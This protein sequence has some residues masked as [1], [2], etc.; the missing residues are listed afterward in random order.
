MDWNWYKDL[1]IVRKNLKTKHSQY[2]V[3]NE[4]SLTAYEMLI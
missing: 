2:H 3:V 1:K 4:L